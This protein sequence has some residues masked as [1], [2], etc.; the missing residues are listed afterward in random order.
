MNTPTARTARA[1]RRPRVQVSARSPRPVVA[2]VGRSTTPPPLVV[3]IVGPTETPL[4]MRVRSRRPP[5][6]RR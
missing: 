2:V 6:E 1:S 4:P 3:R 5:K